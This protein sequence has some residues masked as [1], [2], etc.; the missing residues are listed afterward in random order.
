MVNTVDYNA[1]CHRQR[2]A[3]MLNTITT[4]EHNNG[5]TET[6]GITFRIW[7]ATCFMNTEKMSGILG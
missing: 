1:K 2:M 3:T 7:R 4:I 6:C 5:L